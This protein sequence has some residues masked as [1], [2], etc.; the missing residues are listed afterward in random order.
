LIAVVR[1]QRRSRPAYLGLRDR[2][3]DTLTALQ[4]GLSGIRVVQSFGRERERFDVYRLRSD[5]NVAAW[6]R[7][8]L[9]N[10]GF[11]P[12]ISLAQAIS[13]A[14]VVAAGGV[15]HSRG[16]VSTGT[17]VAFALYLSSLFEPIARLGDWFSEFQSGRAA[18]TK[19]VGLLE[20]PVT[21][22]DADEAVSLPGDRLEQARQVER[23]R[24]DSPGAHLAAR[25]EHPAGGENGG[26]RDCLR[27]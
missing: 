18:L 11:F 27:E 10:I 7:V 4:E 8:S 12:A 21:V 1:Y 17:V 26:H 19:I 5:A 2:V 15:L 9:V 16:E 22:A 3:A 6:R 23:E 24:D 25:V 13:A 20:T 14:A